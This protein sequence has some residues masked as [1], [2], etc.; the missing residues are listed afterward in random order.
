MS[1]LDQD[2][3][4]AQLRARGELPH[5]SRGDVLAQ[6]LAAIEAGMEDLRAGIIGDRQPE[7]LVLEIECGDFSLGG[8]VRV[9]GREI[10]FAGRPAGIRNRDL[11]AVWINHLALSA[12]GYAASSYYLGLE[13]QKPAARRFAPLTAETARNLLGDLLDIYWSGLN[14]PLHFFPE[15]SGGFA[16]ELLKSNDAVKAA[17]RATT[18][19]QGSYYAAGE[20]EDDYYRLAL[21]DA[22]P[23]ENGFSEL[24]LNIWQ[25]LLENME[26]GI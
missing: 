11:L 22:A 20:G 16:A 13:R 10:C 1:E 12:A 7:D 18:A 2:D 21:G 9:Y 8:L 14:K 19:W 17:A 25:P 5:G 3:L 6:D 4:L 26:A 15:T 23:L 24:A